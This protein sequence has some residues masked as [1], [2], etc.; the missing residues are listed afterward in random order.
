MQLGAGKA[1]RQPPS[2]QSALR[3]SARAPRQREG[4]HV[5]RAYGLGGQDTRLQLAPGEELYYNGCSGNNDSAVATALHR[6]P[7]LVI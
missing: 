1:L 3:H 6:P 7:N 2:R 4:L 5:F